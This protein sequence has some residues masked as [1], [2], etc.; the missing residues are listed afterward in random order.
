MHQVRDGG[1]ERKVDV[2]VEDHM[3][4]DFGLQ[5]GLPPMIA[6]PLAQDAPIKSA[7]RAAAAAASQSVLLQFAG[8]AI[9]VFCFLFLYLS[10]G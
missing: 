7:R 9:C 6:A 1:V 3:G 4:A 2:A 5:V 10:K 8:I